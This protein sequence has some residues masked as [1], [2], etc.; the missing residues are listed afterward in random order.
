[1]NEEAKRPSHYDEKMDLEIAR[2]LLP[3]VLQWLKSGGGTDP[4]DEERH[5]I[6]EQLTSAC[7]FHDDG[8]EV[9]KELD[10]RHMW[11]SDSS[12][13][14]VLDEIVNL[15]HRIHEKVVEAWVQQHGVVP[16]YSVGQRVAFKRQLWDKEAI[17]GEVTAVREKTA[18][19][20]VFCESLGHVRVGLG[21][22]GT[23]VAF[24]DVEAV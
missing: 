14:D 7:R 4:T 24:E 16:Q 21:S 19:Y 6:L 3:K 15:R 23:Y 22:H 5:D 9:A 11:D 17:T 2:V 12:L 8:Y 18:Q 1:M 10:N 13:V 20:L